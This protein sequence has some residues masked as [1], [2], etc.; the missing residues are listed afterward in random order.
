[1]RFNSAAPPWRRY[2]GT[3]LNFISENTAPT[4]AIAANSG[5]FTELTGIKVNIVTLELSAM[6]QQVALDFASGE[7]GY[8][9]IYADPYQVLAPYSKALVDLREL[10]ADPAMPPLPGGLGDFIPAQLDAAGKFIDKE[11]VYCLP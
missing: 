9:V 1:M 7:A 4:A 11:K 6:V 3:T 10:M 5:P 2:A 8:H